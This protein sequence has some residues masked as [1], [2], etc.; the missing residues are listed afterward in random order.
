[1]LIHETCFATH[2]Q[3]PHGKSQT[4]RAN[5]NI[6]R[7][8]C[9]ML[10]KHCGFH[11]LVP[12]NKLERE[13]GNRRH[14]RSFHCRTV[15]LK[16]GLP[17][18]WLLQTSFHTLLRDTLSETTAIFTS[19]QVRFRHNDPKEYIKGTMEELQ[20]GFLGPLPDSKDCINFDLNNVNKWV[21]RVSLDRQTSLV[22]LRAQLN[23][24]RREISVAM[25]TEFPSH[26]HY[27]RPAWFR[28]RLVWR[29]VVKPLQWPFAHWRSGCMSLDGWTYSC[30]SIPATAR[31]NI[32]VRGIEM[33][34]MPPMPWEREGFLQCR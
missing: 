34:S 14:S 6:P 29:P 28:F 31:V 9:F 11:L 23:C 12:G 18:P 33:C 17:N 10:C 2:S 8:L 21:M 26:Q 25:V 27:G 32:V 22:P 13:Y 3:A 24:W 20:S 4:P 16:E 1:M 19:V 30:F 7:A 5:G 15:I